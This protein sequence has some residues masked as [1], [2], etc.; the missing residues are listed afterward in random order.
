MESTICSLCGQTL[1]GTFLMLP[2]VECTQ[3]G[4]KVCE[5]CATKYA[6]MCVDCLDFSKGSFGVPS[7]LQCVNPNTAFRK[8]KGV[9]KCSVCLDYT[10]PHNLNV[11][12]RCLRETCHFCACTCSNFQP[13]LKRCARCDMRTPVIHTNTQ[14][15]VM[16]HGCALLDEVS[17]VLPKGVAG[18]V[19]SYVSDEIYL[20]RGKK[21]ERETEPCTPPPCKKRKTFTPSTDQ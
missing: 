8:Y 11:C 7:C 4:N 12:G 19:A 9:F 13:Y 20:P 5:P 18:L 10:C 21:R 1:V 17:D 16:C 3:C 15:V 2:S 6:R 14:G